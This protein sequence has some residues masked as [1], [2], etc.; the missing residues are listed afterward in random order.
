M[1]STSSKKRLGRPP[2]RPYS[3]RYLPQIARNRLATEQWTAEVA[4][5]A[6]AGPVIGAYE[7]FQAQYR[8]D[9]LGFVR[10]CI[11]WPDGDGPAPYQAEIMGQVIP[12]K[13]VCVRG[14]HG[15]GK[16]ALAAWLILW[17]ALV[18]DGSDWKVVTTASAWRQVEKFLW[19]EIHKW[20][21]MVLWDKVG[22]QPFTQNELLQLTLKLNTGAAFGVVSDNPALIEGAHA[23]HIMYVFDESKTIPPATFDAAEGALTGSQGSEAY[24]VSISTPGDPVGR[25]YDIQKRKPG[26]DDWWVRHVTKAECIAAGRMTEAWSEQRKQ[27][28]GEESAV[29]KN[30]VEGEF[31]SADED[32]VIPLSWIEKANER[33]TDLKGRVERGEAEWEPFTCVGVDVARSGEDKTV[34]A[35]R[36]GQAI[37]ELRTFAKA[38]T[39]ETAGRVSGILRAHG[40]AAVI[41]VVGIGAGVLDRVR[42]LGL[43]TEAFNAGERTAWLDRSGEQGFVDSRAAAWWCL[44][45]LLDPAHGEQVALPP[46]D[47]LIGDL[48]APKWRSMSGGRVRVE[49]KDDIRKRLGRSTDHADAVV[50]AFWYG[51]QNGPPILVDN[52]W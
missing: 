9:P 21:R 36:H 8:L 1:L 4:A 45:E 12:K 49:S 51:E 47:R 39:M 18:H 41:D 37:T 28:W 35:M 24:A 30:R 25:F 17:F 23:D 14:P 3:L 52:P 16:T 44:R 33:W 43:Q 50:Q 13:R 22:R 34:L 20:S 32:G 6:A 40:G 48:S 42:E 46:D 5:A 10:E 29:Y 11:W 26:Y 2:L 31:A 27:Q 38:D 15:L 19:P 7:Q